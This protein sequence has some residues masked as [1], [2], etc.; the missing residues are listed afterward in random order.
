[1]SQPEFDTTSNCLEQVKDERGVI[2]E[3]D[4]TNLIFST[5]FLSFL[6][7]T[8]ILNNFSKLDTFK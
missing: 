4:P 7:F 1:M 2:L 8:L 5:F 6:M 3:V